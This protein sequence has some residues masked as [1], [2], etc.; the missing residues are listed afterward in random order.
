MYF[1]SSDLKDFHIQF[2]YAIILI[3]VVNNECGGEINF[4]FLFII[5]T[6]V[7]LLPSAVDCFNIEQIYFEQQIKYSICVLSQLKYG[8]IDI[9]NMFL[10]I[11]IYLMNNQT[12]NTEP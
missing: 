1:M 8:T 9:E 2:F 5:K 7:Q 11:R 3:C 12:W 10:F 4:I 6:L